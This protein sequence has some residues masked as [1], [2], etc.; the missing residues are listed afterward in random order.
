MINK[1]Y[2][3]YVSKVINTRFNHFKIFEN[4]Y[5][6]IQQDCKPQKMISLH[7]QNESEIIAKYSV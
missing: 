4:E 6:S 7:D 1:E 2:F 3:S 5:Y